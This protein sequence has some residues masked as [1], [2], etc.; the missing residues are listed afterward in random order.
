MILNTGEMIVYP[1]QG[2]CRVGAVI[3]KDFGGGPTSCYP[4]AVMDESGDMLFVPIN[5]INTLGIR[6]LMGKSE[7]LRLLHRLSQEVAKEISPSTPR[8]WRSRAIDNSKLLAS[9]SAFDLAEIIRSLN[10][11]NKTK[12]LSARDR[13]LL[14]Q[15]RKILIC[16]IS[17]VMSK[18]RSVA[19]QMVDDALNAQK[20]G[21]TERK[22]QG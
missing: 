18:T 15:A 9:G 3:T 11:S 5:K 19:E 10:A 20:P 13:Q 6:R 12:L 1:H 2:P 17:E 4:L 7:I 22:K 14:D 21:G 16:E 8:S